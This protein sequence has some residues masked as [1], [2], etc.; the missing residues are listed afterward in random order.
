M[1]LPLFA[2]SRTARNCRMGIPCPFLL[3]TCR[4]GIPMPFSLFARSCTAGAFHC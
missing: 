1:S 2:R 4:K 3:R